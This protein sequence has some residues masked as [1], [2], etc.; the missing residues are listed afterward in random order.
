MVLCGFFGIW[1]KHWKILMFWIQAPV[2]QNISDGKRFHLSVFHLACAD[3]AFRVR[4]VFSG[5]METV[6]ERRALSNSLCSVEIAVWTGKGGIIKMNLLNKE[7]IIINYCACLPWQSKMPL[8]MENGLYRQEDFCRSTGMGC[9]NNFSSQ[10]LFLNILKSR[11]VTWEQ[12]YSRINMP[13]QHFLSMF[14]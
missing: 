4:D 13:V 9:K 10:K 3:C 5:C 11:A 14:F 2:L 12:V 7:Q 1:V 8:R 6:M